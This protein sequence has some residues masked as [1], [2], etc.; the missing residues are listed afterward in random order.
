VLF[1]SCCAV[2]LPQSPLPK[3]GRLGL[4]CAACSLQLGFWASTCN[5]ATLNDK[6]VWPPVV[7]RG[8]VLPPPNT[9]LLLQSTYTHSHPHTPHTPA[10]PRPTHQVPWSPRV[11][12]VPSRSART[13]RPWTRGGGGPPPPGGGGGGGGGG[14]RGRGGWRVRGGVRGERGCKRGEGEGKEEGRRKEGESVVCESAFRDQGTGY[15]HG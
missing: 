13:T 2:S 11:V 5:T 8:H 14:G 9:R 7:Y 15:M 10:T 1:V 12:C 4:T 6:T 3:L